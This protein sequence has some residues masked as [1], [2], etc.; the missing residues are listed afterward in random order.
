MEHST[1][2]I[3]TVV[4]PKSSDHPRNDNTL[5]NEIMTISNEPN[6]DI[7]EGNNIFNNVPIL[8]ERN[9]NKKF[10]N[11]NQYDIN[12]RDKLTDESIPQFESK[13]KNIQLLHD[14]LSSIQPFGEFCMLDI[15]SEGMCFSIIESNICKIRLN[16]NKK[17]F[18]SYT[19]N[20]VWREKNS[21]SDSQLYAEDTDLSDDNN[22]IEQKNN[23]DDN[24]I[25]NDFDKDSII[26]INLNLTLFLEMINVQV[27]DKNVDQN[28]GCTF[29]FHRDGDPFVMEFEDELI[30]EKCELRTYYVDNE[31]NRGNNKR[32]K[33]KVKKKNNKNES[34]EENLIKYFEI[35]NHITDDT[36]FRLNNRTILYDIIIKSP[37]LFDIIKDMSDLNTEN[38]IIYCKK[39]KDNEGLE[40]DPKIIFISKSKSDSIGFSKLIVE[41]RKHN[42]PEFKLFR[43]ILSTERANEYDF[44]DCYDLSLSSTYRFSYFSKLLKSIRLSRLIKIRKDMTGITSLLLLLGKNSISQGKTRHHHHQ[45]QQQSD[46]DELYGSSIEFTTSESIS[47]DELSSLSIQSKGP[48]LLGKLGYNDKFVE[49]LIKDDRDI[50]TIRIGNDGRLITLDDYFQFNQP[51]VEFEQLENVYNKHDRT[52]SESNENIFPIENN[53]TNENQNSKTQDKKILKLTEKLTMSLL[54]HETP[55][56]IGDKENNGIEIEQTIIEDD[57]ENVHKKRERVSNY[58]DNSGIN[59]KK[60]K[61]STRKGKSKK[62]SKKE[63]DGIETVGGAIEI[64]LFI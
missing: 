32:N 38:F 17:L 44:E 22:E 59:N 55:I 8:A 10:E 42:V 64:P 43:P 2:T 20:G 19:F 47:I 53:G 18:K 14:L 54:G 41:Q 39:S 50:Q 3:S 1:G 45:Q 12:T 27:K 60:I 52:R 46:Y 29:R 57:N 23:R 35:E 30:V 40:K 63:N 13:T 4:D 26:S 16:I 15:S 61:G 34:Q 6:N 58:R 33:K 25:I 9:N 21:F 51:N 36:I 11:N 48:S 28:I 7:I 31:E 37:I 62:G 5:T 24:F 56:E 49:Q